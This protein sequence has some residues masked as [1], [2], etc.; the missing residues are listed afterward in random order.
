MKTI[1]TTLMSACLALA[2]GSA[3]AQDKP[4][5]DAMSR[6]GAADK[7]MTMQECKDH[8]TMSKREGATKD[9]AMMKKDR[10]CADMM[11]KEGMSDE[12]KN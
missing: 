8:M 7:Q 12:K 3:L 11:K 10:M 9:A 6:E 1:A 5:N 2:A 4:K